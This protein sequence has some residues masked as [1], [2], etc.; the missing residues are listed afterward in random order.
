[1]SWLHCFLGRWNN[2]Q[3]FVMS[4]ALTNSTW[5]VGYRIV[6]FIQVVSACFSL[7]TLPVWKINKQR[8]VENGARNIGF[9][10]EL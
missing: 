9:C 1:M 3:P 7:I 2:S 5:N 8:K 10:L 4:Y 6:G